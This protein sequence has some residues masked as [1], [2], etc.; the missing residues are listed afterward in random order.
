MRFTI[1]RV[2]VFLSLLGVVLASVLE[3]RQN[4]PHNSKPF[5]GFQCHDARF[6]AEFLELVTN[7]IK[8]LPIWLNQPR[9][10][11]MYGGAPFAR[12]YLIW[13]ISLDTDDYDTALK[14]RYRAVLTLNG[15][16]ELFSV[17]DKTLHGIR[18]CRMDAPKALVQIKHDMKCGTYLFKNHKLLLAAMSACKD[19]LQIATHSFPARY[20]GPHFS[21]FGEQRYVYPIKYDELYRHNTEPGPFR[22]VV[23]SRCNLIGAVTVYS[24]GES[25]KCAEVQNTSGELM[26]RPKRH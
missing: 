14:G 16:Y 12:Q 9:F 18:E 24:N 3:P 4:D 10:S 15:K 2:S 7:Q 23:D 19:I 5:N 6:S 21:S 13:P 1:T 26:K 25:F 11:K 22:V 17:I 8:S 20:D